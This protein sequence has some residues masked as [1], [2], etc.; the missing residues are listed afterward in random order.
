MSNGPPLKLPKG[1][2]PGMTSQVSAT[3][4]STR[5]SATETAIR[6]EARFMVRLLISLRK[7]NREVTLG[8]PGVYRDRQRTQ[9]ERQASL[10]ELLNPRRYMNSAD[11]LPA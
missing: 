4:A 10:K 1:S 6:M 11:R 5:V 7:S 2:K 8:K 3:C 9:I